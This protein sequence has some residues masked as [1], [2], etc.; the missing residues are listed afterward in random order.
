MTKTELSKFRRLLLDR[1]RFLRWGQAVPQSLE[2]KIDSI[3]RKNGREVAPNIRTN[4]T[5]PI[6]AHKSRPLQLPPTP[7]THGKKFVLGVTDVSVV[8]VNRTTGARMPLVEMSLPTVRYGFY[9]QLI[10]KNLRDSIKAF[11]K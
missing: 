2:R 7:G 3:K 11:V 1:G 6:P 10:R 4:R 8:L 5:K 9:S